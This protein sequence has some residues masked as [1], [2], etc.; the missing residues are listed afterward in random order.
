MTHGDLDP[1]SCE[2]LI[3]HVKGVL[4]AHVC[5]DA[6]GFGVVLI[7]S[8]SDRN[9]N[10]I[11]KDAESVLRNS[12]GDISQWKI[13][14]SQ[15]DNATARFCQD[16]RVRLVGLGVTMDGVMTQTRVTVQYRGETS[17]GVVK[18]VACRREGLNL[19]AEATIKA[20]EQWSYRGCRLGV[21]GVETVCFGSSD[22]IVVGLSCSKA[23]CLWSGSC[24]VKTSQREAAVRATL[25]AVNRQFVRICEKHQE[26]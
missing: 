4:S 1:K 20:I 14:V 9:P 19:A 3:R 15:A 22:I 25:N 17:T 21:G 12:V 5:V 23:N 18:G 6:Q 13:T 24:Y 16:S 8:Q 7:I 2:K 10:L 26:L 11:I